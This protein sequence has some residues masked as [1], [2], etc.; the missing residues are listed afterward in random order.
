MMRIIPTFVVLAFVL[1]LSIAV[2]AQDAPRISGFQVNLF[3][4]KTGS[5]SQDMLSAGAPEMGNVPSG[6]FASVSVFVAV[7]I[8]FGINASIPQKMQVR[9]VAT[10]NGSMPFAAKRAKAVDRVIMD[11]T[12]VLGP[13]DANGN[14]YVGFWL[15][16]TG[17]R[18]ISLKASLNGVKNAN[19]KTVILPFACYE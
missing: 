14:T 3:N 15:P 19:S 17:C 11:S 9:L 13:I 7:Q 18:S 4:S 5:F 2:A 6:E 12:S 10:E 1:T 16:K 8:E